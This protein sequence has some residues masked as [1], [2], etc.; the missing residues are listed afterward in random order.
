MAQIYYRNGV[1]DFINEDLES[2]IAEWEKALVCNP[3]HEKASENIDNARR[4]LEKIE[5]LP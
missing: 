5:T 1:K 2:A 3:D 4:L